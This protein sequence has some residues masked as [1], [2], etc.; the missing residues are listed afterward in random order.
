MCN[1]CIVRG[2]NPPAV[3]TQNAPVLLENKI[4]S[5]SPYVK[6]GNDV[7]TTKSGIRLILF[8][9]RNGAF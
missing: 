4:T 7:H 9:N 8:S 3:S 1:L 2:K 6:T 5:G